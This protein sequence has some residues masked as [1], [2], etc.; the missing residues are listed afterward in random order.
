MSAVT[1]TSNSSTTN[2]TPFDI[3]QKVR[4]TACYPHN[5]VDKVKRQAVILT[6]IADGYDRS[7]ANEILPERE[8]FSVQ[9]PAEPEADDG[10]FSNGGETEPLD[11]DDGDIYSL[12]EPIST[13]ADGIKEYYLNDDGEPVT[14]IEAKGRY[15]GK[16][17]GENSLADDYD[18]TNNAHKRAKRR[19]YLLS[20]GDRRLVEKWYNDQL[21]TALISLRLSQSE[22]PK[23]VDQMREAK[24]AFDSVIRKLRY[25]LTKSATGPQ[26]KSEEFSYAYV[27]AGTTDYASIHI[28]LLVYVRGSVDRDCFAG[29][30]NEWVDKCD[31]APSDGR[32]NRLDGGTVSIRQNDNIPLTDDGRTAGMKYVSNQIPHIA[33]LTD[34]KGKTDTLLFYSTVDAY[35]HRGVGWS[36]NWPITM[37]EVDSQFDF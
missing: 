32:G 6:V 20:E 29:V 16:R 19:F 34:L 9:E 27:Y 36:R 33:D 13:T 11:P 5:T 30:L 15:Y 24:P 2:S 23:R 4:D 14:A 35:D 7:E 26:L 18:L 28:H 12:Q 22:C 8:Y 25:D 1:S 10:D 37:K 31:Y 3:Q 21:T 17:V